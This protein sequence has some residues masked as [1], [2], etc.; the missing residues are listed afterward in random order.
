MKTVII[1]GGTRGIG[2]AC[3]ERFCNEGWNVAFFYLSRKDIA[4]EIETSYNCFS[5]QCD[6][7]N[8]SDVKEAISAVA[9]KFGTV[10]LLVNNAGV[11]FSGLLQ[12]MSDDD[13]MKV[14]NTNL[15]SA[16]YTS[17]ELIPI[18]LK[19]GGGSIINVSSM[20]GITGASCEV[21]YSASKAGIIGFTKALAK[22][23]APSNIRVNAVAP[24]AIATDMLN[25]YSKADLD[26]IAD[27]TPLGTLGKAKNIADAV[28]F[29]A[30]ES[31]SFITGEVLNVNGGFVI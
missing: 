3:V 11:S 26:A 17:R 25:E 31:A 16:F 27:D 24:G 28:W 4:Q 20:W 13:W 18:L 6:I 19:N 12:D 23:L 29:L 7:S 5:V 21:A 10:D 14:I 8:S 1:T 30:N 2:R 15:T 9:K 22:E